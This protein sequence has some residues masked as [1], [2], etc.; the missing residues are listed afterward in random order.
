L[1]TTLQVLAFLMSLTGL[2]GVFAA[3]RRKA[4]LMLFFQLAFSALV[5]SQALWFSLTA[6]KDVGAT[7]YVGYG[8]FTL[9]DAL[10][11]MLMFL[12]F[13][14]ALYA[15]T[16][17]ISRRLR[18]EPASTTLKQDEPRTV[19]V[20][21]VRETII[22]SSVA[23][24]VASAMILN[25]GG[26][27]NFVFSPG[28]MI[29][30]QT[31]LLLALGVLKWNVLNRLS[32]RMPV[33]AMSL[34]YF[35]IYL[36]FCLFTSRFLAVFSMLQLVMYLHYYKRPISFSRLFVAMIPIVA[37][38]FI[39]GIY[40]DISRNEVVRDAPLEDWV[41]AVLVFMPN[42][43][44]W[45]FSNNTEIFSG[46]ADAVRQLREGAEIDLLVPEFRAVFLLLPNFIR[47][48]GDLFFASLVEGLT[49]SGVKSNS[50]IASGF[51]RF[52]LGLGIPGFALYGIVLLFFLYAAELTL[53]SQRRS[54][55]AVTSVQALNG[56]RGSLAGVLL[57]FGVADFIASKVFR[58]CLLGQRDSRPSR[59]VYDSIQ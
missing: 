16:L 15:T 5:T 54:F 39:Y 24:V 34:A 28:D 2:M 58:L 44:D 26:I 3:F 40:R 53:R 49:A 12:C 37:V 35:G 57:F 48:D 1:Y 30:G 41:A 6:V 11:T 32:Y 36:F 13:Q 20:S 31:F 42:F 27:G 46:V 4:M 18:S 14:V 47:T 55:L 29:P 7:Q 17:F 9:Q 8:A 21:R 50:V 56:M 22:F 51:E 10:V 23:L 43:F 25:A 33:S 52:V 59:P 45:F 19:S 38:V